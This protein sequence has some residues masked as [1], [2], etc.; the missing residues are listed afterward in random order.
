MYRHWAWEY[1]DV[2]DFAHSFD[3]MSQPVP[4]MHRCG[5]LVSVSKPLSVF[6]DICSCSCIHIVL[7]AHTRVGLNDALKRSEQ[8]VALC[9]HR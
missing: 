3:T 8:S 1:D 4:R 7:N 6:G 5:G 9:F 2:F